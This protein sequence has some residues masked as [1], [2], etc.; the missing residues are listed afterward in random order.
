[1]K[2]D[3]KKYTMTLLRTVYFMFAASSILWLLYNYATFNAV[4][5]G[6]L[7]LGAVYGLL[8]LASALNVVRKGNY[9]AG[10]SMD[11]LSVGTQKLLRF[12]GIS[13]CAPALF[14]CGMFWLCVASFDNTTNAFERMKTVENVEL[15]VFGKTVVGAYIFGQAVPVAPE[16]TPKPTLQAQEDVD[17]GPYMARMQ[18]T[19][20]RSWFPPK[21]NTSERVVAAWTIARNGSLSNLRITQPATT[22]TANK[23]ALKAVQ[24][25]APFDTL[26]EGS[27]ESV[28]ISFTFDYNVFSGGHPLTDNADHTSDAFSS[29]LAED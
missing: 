8:T 29:R 3:A 13:L 21:R 10:S 25:S 28:D 16:P 1:M 12:A 9:L 5:V 19:I 18:R 2:K 24:D 27:P 26:P 11:V 23:A 4:T 17:F 22:D 20:K 6:L 7:S 14:F 15:A